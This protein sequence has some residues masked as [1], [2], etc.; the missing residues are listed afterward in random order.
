VVVVVSIGEAE[1]DLETEEEG[2]EALMA[3]EEE[4]GEDTAVEEEEDSEVTGDLPHTKPC[5]K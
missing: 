1:E 5:L 2:E 4:V 3:E